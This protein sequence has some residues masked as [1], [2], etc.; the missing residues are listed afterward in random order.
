MGDLGAIPSRPIR[1]SAA[2]AGLSGGDRPPPDGLSRGGLI[3]EVITDLD[4]SYVGLAGVKHRVRELASLFEIDRLRANLGVASAPPSLHMCFT[5]NPGT[6][7]TMIAGAMGRILHSLGYLERGHVVRASRENLIGQ[8]V[9]HT[10][11]RAHAVVHS[12]I[13]GVLFI[14][15]AYSIHREGSDRDFGHEV[16]EILLEA[17]ETHRDNLAVVLAGYPDRIGAFFQHN[18]GLTSRVTHHIRFPDYD[19]DELMQIAALMLDDRSY[20]FSPEAAL[21][22]RHRLA[23]ASR[24]P[25]FGNGRA[26]RNMIDLARLRHADRVLRVHAPSRTQ[27]T[28]LE[29]A[30]IPDRPDPLDDQGPSG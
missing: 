29:A 15:E 4:H 30:D 7:K 27:L 6:G 24:Q 28:T 13:G 10:A 21:A 17:M 2:P 3:D 1:H 25:G 19:I 8:H 22:A 14:D 16:I 20:R 9:G 23:A 18:P 26:V 5:G 11:P 12:A